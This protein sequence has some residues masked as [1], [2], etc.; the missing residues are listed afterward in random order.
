MHEGAG[1]TIGVVTD[2]LGLNPATIRAW[3]RRG[4]LRPRRR[5]RHRLYSDNDLRRLEFIRGL[6]D[7]GLNLAGIRQL[8]AL[9]PCWFMDECPACARRS[10]HAACARPCWKERGT[11]CAVSVEEPSVCERCPYRP[12]GT[13]A[14]GGDAAP[15]GTRGR[16]VE[17][18][19]PG[20]SRP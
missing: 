13:A 10:N 1:Y 17:G 6:L 8:V 14:P 7:Q 15:A 11:Y 20:A 4:L 12:A 16:G 19:G 2:L 5:N 9:Y 3:E 18:A